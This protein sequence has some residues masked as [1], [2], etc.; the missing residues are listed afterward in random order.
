LLCSRGALFTE[1]PSLVLGGGL[2]ASHAV[3]CNALRSSDDAALT[4]RW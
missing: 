1:G 3:E 4:A 2:I